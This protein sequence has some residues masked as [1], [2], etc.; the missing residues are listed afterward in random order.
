M[1]SPCRRTVVLG[2]VAWAASWALPAHAAEPLSIG[3]A[4][5]PATQTVNGVELQRNGA[6]VRYK[7]VFKVYAAAL[8][9]P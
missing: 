4:T 5:F 3:G 6:G 2:T 1:P 8:Y 7:A 9:L